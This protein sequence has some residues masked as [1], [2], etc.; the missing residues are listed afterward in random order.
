MFELP[1]PEF[2]KI[3]VDGNELEVLLGGVQ[4]L[5]NPALRSILVEVREDSD[6]ERAVRD[7]LAQFSFLHTGTG[8]ATSAGFANLEFERDGG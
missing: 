2:L 5:S 3:D 4:T 1:C 6:V 8:Y 7:L